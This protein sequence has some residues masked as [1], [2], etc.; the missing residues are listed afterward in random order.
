MLFLEF[1]I[2]DERYALPTNRIVEIAPMV[3]L[4]KIPLAHEYVA[5]VMNYRSQ[6]IPI[7]DLNQLYGYAA[8]KQR[9][10]TRIILLEYPV[11]TQ[12]D[13]FLGLLAEH[14]TGTLNYKPEDFEDTGLPGLARNGLRGI[15]HDAQGSVQWIQAEDLLPADVRN[16]LFMQVESEQDSLCAAQ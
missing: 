16:D 13:K 6:P 2:A 10:S 7:I 9:I 5:G 11:T 15:A 1:H 8:A 3:H 4:K 12:E 14:V